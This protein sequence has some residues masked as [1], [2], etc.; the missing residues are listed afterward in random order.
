MKSL[1]ICTRTA[2]SKTIKRHGVTHVLSLTDADKR[3]FLHPSFNKV[4]WLWLKFED[5]LDAKDYYAPSPEHV[6]TILEWGSRLPSDAVL[7]V[8]CEA[9]VSRSTATAL[10]LLVQERGVDQIDQC[11]EYLLSV[12]P[13]ACP[14]PLI[15]LYADQQLG[16]GGRLH[17]ASEEV[18]KKAVAKYL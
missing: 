14:N 11:V 16:C 1:H 4:N 10:A 17:A 3:P 9:G 6:Q 8:H 5:V 15:T 2:V 7:L 13:Q 18:A 12:R